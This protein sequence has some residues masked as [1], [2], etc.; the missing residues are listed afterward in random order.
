M[1]ALR[2]ISGV[3]AGLNSQATE[4]WYANQDNTRGY[5]RACP[6]GHGLHRHP[7]WGRGEQ[8]AGV[9]FC[10]ECGRT[11]GVH[12]VVLH[13]LA[14]LL[15]RTGHL[16]DATAQA[17]SLTDYQRKALASVQETLTTLEQA[18]GRHGTNLDDDPEQGEQEG[19]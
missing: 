8:R 19:A 12:P 15:T 18:W 9:L 7:N 17:D 3:A 11:A 14:E 13:A 1:N 5:E 4:A 16:T 2:T 10:Q 6:H